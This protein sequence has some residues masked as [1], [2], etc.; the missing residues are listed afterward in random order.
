VWD[1]TEPGFEYAGLH[2]QGSEQLFQC[3]KWGDEFEAHK[4][5]FHELSEMEAY[6]LGRTCKIQNV[7][8][9][10]TTGRVEAMRLALKLKF[11]D[12]K[13]RAL[14]LST[15]GHKLV[16]IKGDSYWGICFKGQGQNML[17]KLLEELREKI[18]EH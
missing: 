15:T 14:L 10:K 18:N 12:E 16:S 4:H 8:E 7:E 6:A 1:F 11:E 9:W 5:Q 2:W 3:L 17:G 13:L